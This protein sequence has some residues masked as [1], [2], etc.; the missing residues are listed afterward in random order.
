MSD[1]STTLGARG[2]AGRRS[3]CE[4]TVRSPPS[5]IARTALF[6]GGA[7]AFTAAEKRKLLSPRLRD[8]YGDASSW[9]VVKPIY[10]RFVAGAADPSPLNW[11]TYIDL[12]ICLPKL[13]LIRVD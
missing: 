6:W 2:N 12:N 7:D 5:D 9:D 13:L 8:M 11:M 10:E 1:V 3:R 4:A